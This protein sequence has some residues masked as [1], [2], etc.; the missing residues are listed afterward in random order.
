MIQKIQ[1]KKLL[2]SV[3]FLS[4]S[5]FSF[6]QSKI[7]GTFQNEVGAPVEFTPIAL[8]KLNDT[9]VYMSTITDEK[10][11]FE[12]L[13]PIASTFLIKLKNNLFQPYTSTAIEIQDREVNLGLIKLIS[14]VQKIEE[15]SVVAKKPILTV[16]AEKTILN[17]ANITNMTG[18]NGL[19][20]LRRTPGVMIDKDN[21]IS[22]K[23]KTDVRIFIDN[24]PSQMANEDLVNLLKG[25][26][27]A[28][29][30]AIEVITNPSSKYDASG[31]GGIIN[32][33]LKKNKGF[34][35]NMSFELGTTRSK[36]EKYNGSFSFNHRDK[37]FNI[38][39]NYSLSYGAWENY[40]DLYREQGNYI[41]NQ[42][43]TMTNESANH[44]AKF[45]ADY[46]YNKKNTFGAN[47]TANVQKGN[48]TSESRSPF[49]N[50][51]TN[52]IEQILI[53]SNTQPFSNI[54]LNGNLN[55]R[56]SDT[57]GNKFSTDAD[58]GYFSKEQ[59]SYQPNSYM[60]A[61]ELT[62]L[63]K[64]IYRNTT[65]TTIQ[66]KTLKSDYERKLKKTNISLGYKISNVETD[67]TFNFYNVINESSNL[68][69]TRSNTFHYSE[70]VYA[71]YF[72]L[73]RSIQKFDIQV[74]VRYEHTHSIG[75]LKSFFQNPDPV[76]RNY[77]N[78]FPSTAITYHLN[79]KNTFTL[80]YSKRIDR[81]N[82]QD[83]NPFE[84]KLNELSYQKGNA[85][86]KPQYSN[87][88]EL[89]HVF[90]DFLT[91]SIGY[92]RTNDYMTEIIDTINGKASYITQTNLDYVNNYNFNLSVPIPIRKWWFG[93]LNFSLYRNEYHANFKDGK[94]INL[95]NTAYNVY[96]S[97]SF[98]LPKG[99]SIEFSGWYNSPTIM[100]ATFL[101]RRMYSIDAGFKKKILNGKGDLKLNFSDIFH[102]QIWAGHS[103]YAGFYMNATGGWESRQIRLNFAY[104]FGNTNVKSEQH[105]TG[106]E[107][108]K[109][110]IKT[111]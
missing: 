18:I 75:T 29:I 99:W 59:S 63:Q 2:F 30:E 77:G 69:S 36:T 22:L 101:G 6:S 68:D 98:T 71:G 20:V 33:L 102:T 14:I 44:N 73:N 67:N 25:M 1:L 88:F 12:F 60:S 16:T 11:Y 89:S 4:F 111:K 27:A 92:T 57:L 81:P 35:N 37:Y 23:G 82:Y 108:E 40:M 65:P 62:L 104:R 45:G 79:P 49:T 52:T 41:Y 31:T 42:H 83:L 94:T 76:D 47:I 96:M 8:F 100:V 38:F 56:Y 53:A 110:R 24:R 46:F 87:A 84:N 61:D 93:F 58:M 34:G 74:G 5:T 13:N 86:L 50:I 32:I 105:K 95:G 90:M 64:N 97:N 54:N 107:D 26:N 28:D 3:L 15:V 72:N 48:W 55:Y 7:S 21:N 43:T 106:S 17:V 10:G 91:T 19:E 109:N 51:Q 85:F 80:T 78:F 9:L 66:I 70:T 103:N 39:S